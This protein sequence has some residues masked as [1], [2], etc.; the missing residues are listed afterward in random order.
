MKV[1][2]ITLHT[3]LLQNNNKRI[4]VEPT[5]TQ[6]QDTLQTVAYNDLSFRRLRGCLTKPKF[7]TPLQEKI[8]NKIT[9]Y[10]KVLPENSRLKAPIVMQFEDKIIEFS[11][12]KTNPSGLTDVSIKVK[13]KDDN[14]SE[15]NFVISK[16]GQ[17]KSGISQEPN[18]MGLM[19]ERNAYGVRKMFYG[20]AIYHSLAN[21]DTLWLREGKP[22]EDEISPIAQLRMEFN[23]TEL[24]DF[25]SEMA[26][27]R[28]SFLAK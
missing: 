5:S 23:D 26:K 19:F 2:S 20:N 8:A 1:H 12:D 24:R 7:N 15:L 14:K 6:P 11:M 10:L 9:T 28:T 17:V 25:L 13:D 27:K 16:T 22:Q 4:Q 18:K 21:S 3:G